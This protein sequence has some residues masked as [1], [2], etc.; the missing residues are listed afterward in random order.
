MKI[1]ELDNLIDSKSL[2]EEMMSRFN[3]FIQEVIGKA[4]KLAL[5]I[6]YLPPIKELHRGTIRPS[7]D[8][9]EDQA[10]EFF[11][12]VEANDSNEILELIASKYIYIDR[13]DKSD[14]FNTALIKATT[15]NYQEMCRFLL[16]LG[17]DINMSNVK[18][19]TPLLVAA[20]N[21]NIDLVTMFI[22]RGAAVNFCDDK[23]NTPLHYACLENHRDIVSYLLKVKGICCN[24]ENFNGVRPKWLT[25][26]DEIRQCFPFGPEISHVDP[27]QHV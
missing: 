27:S 7:V 18:R 6:E 16:D 20:K 15:N 10:G 2:N 11:R 21:G 12:A 24:L 8:V 5:E 26:N 3:E 14:S 1:A 4:N 9:L 22:E 25:D 17:A 19:E 23:G 13:R